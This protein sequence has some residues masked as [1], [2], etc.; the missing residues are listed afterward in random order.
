MSCGRL[1]ILRGID[2]SSCT[3]A[4]SGVRFNVPPKANDVLD[5]DEKCMV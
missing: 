5:E 2:R 3:Q 4:S 1:Q